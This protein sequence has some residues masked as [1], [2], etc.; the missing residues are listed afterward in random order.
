MI[1]GVIIADT[2][3]NIIVTFGVRTLNLV[4]YLN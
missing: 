4:S 3:N 1:G 2:D